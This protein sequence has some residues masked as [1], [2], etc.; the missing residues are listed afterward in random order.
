[1]PHGGFIIAPLG[2]AIHAPDDHANGFV[3]EAELA[4]DHRKRQTFAP[5][6]VNPDIAFRSVANGLDPIGHLRINAV[7]TSPVCAILLTRGRRV[8]PR[9]RGELKSR[10]AKAV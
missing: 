9:L 5:T 3:I 8:G 7:F 1:M 6:G 2:N 10:R 4:R